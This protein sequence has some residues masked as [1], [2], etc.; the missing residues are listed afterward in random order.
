MAKTA[1]NKEKKTA[2]KGGSSY[3]ASSI[4]V[5]EVLDPVRNRPGMYIGTT[6]PY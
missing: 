2:S 6:G 5:L 3:D 1:E 4:T